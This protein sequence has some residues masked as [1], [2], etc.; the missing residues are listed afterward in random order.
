MNLQDDISNI[1]MNEGTDE[2]KRTFRQVWDAH[3]TDNDRATITAYVE[4]KLREQG[5]QTAAVIQRVEEHLRVE[6][7]K[8]IL[9][10]AYIAREYFNRTRGWLY[11]RLNGNAVNGKP[12]KFTPE[13]RE[14]F[15][16][17][18]QDLSKKIGSLRLS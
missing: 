5:E 1:K 18:L 10:M 6:D 2:F 17:A 9:P 15:N 8:N 3:P 14:M 4:E 16:V 13:E 12:A 7:M 11:Q